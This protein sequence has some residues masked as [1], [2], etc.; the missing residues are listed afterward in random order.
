MNFND[1]QNLYLINYK[2]F[3]IQV[4][5]SRF[6]LFVWIKSLPILR[7][8]LLQVLFF[9]K[10]NCYWNFFK[11][12]YSK[13]TQE[14]KK[15]HQCHQHTSVLNLECNIG[16]RIRILES[17]YGVA[18]DPNRDYCNEGFK[19]KDCKSQ[20]SFQNACNGRSSCSVHFFQVKKNLFIN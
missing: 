14:L 10:W 12:K 13:F 19:D 8:L 5:F 6:Y 18:A 17:F 15:V 3:S 1:K 7:Y 16:Y 20:T 11:L 9:T 2:F 4:S